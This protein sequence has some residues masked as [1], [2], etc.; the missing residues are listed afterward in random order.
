M[1]NFE[2]SLSFLS[3]SLSK[4]V[5]FILEARILTSLSLR[6]DISIGKL[7]ISLILSLIKLAA[8]PN[9]LSI[10]RKSADI[11]MDIQFFISSSGGL[12]FKGPA[13]SLF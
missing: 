12:I 9:N 5:I 10:L 13:K 8:S 2:I 4:S 6:Q 7:T 3:T 11:K 1:Y